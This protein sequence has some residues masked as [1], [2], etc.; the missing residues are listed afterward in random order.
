MKIAKKL[1]SGLV[2]LAFLGVGVLTVA[3]V[4]KAQS[5]DPAN[6]GDLIILSQLFNGGNLGTSGKSVTV[7][8]G[9]T[10]SG[11][12]KT[13]LGSA[14]LFPEIASLNNIS[15]PNLIFPGEV[16]Q[17]PATTAATLNNGNVLGNNTLGNL[18]I[19]DQ[20][21][22]GNNGG[23]IFGN[24]GVLGNGGSTLGNLFILDQLFGGN[25]NGGI[26]NGGGIL[27]NGNN[28]LGNLFVLDALFGG[29]N[30]GGI[31]GNSGILGNGGSTLGNLFILNQLFGNGTNNL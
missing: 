26:F 13:F 14:S 5:S 28:T 31:F 29:N 23:G 27:G 3:P 20:L 4:V 12:A 11:I 17:L 21:F 15:N 8:S 7:Q 22:G 18:L 9:D 24:G 16:L 30:G 10:L 6:L 19:L 2:A 25:G 1:I